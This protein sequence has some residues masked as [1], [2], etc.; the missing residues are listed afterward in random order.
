MQCCLCS[1][2]F[3]YLFIYMLSSHLVEDPFTSQ[4]DKRMD[5][6]LNA[7][8][9]HCEHSH[10][11]PH[12]H[13]HTHAQRWACISEVSAS[14]E[15]PRCSGFNTIKGETFS[16]S[17]QLALVG[18][19]TVVTQVVGEEEEMALSLLCNFIFVY[20]NIDYWLIPTS[21]IHCCTWKSR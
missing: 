15:G 20:R 13:T 1:S 6:K 11:P 16:L 8:C 12:P 14:P 9:Q 17:I 7:P 18:E 2:L 19:V 5:G 10:P 21:G 3:I 4:D